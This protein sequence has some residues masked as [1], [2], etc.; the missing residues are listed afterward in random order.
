MSNLC[1]VYCRVSTN[2]QD[3]AMQVKMGTTLAQKLGFKEEE[4]TLI[5]DHG[6][7][8]LKVSAHERA[9]LVELRKLVESNRVNTL[10]VYDRDRIARNTIEY[11]SF[12]DVLAKHRVNMVFSNPLAE[13]FD[14]KLSRE[15]QLALDAENEG[16]KIVARTV[17]ASKYYPQSLFGYNKL[18]TKGTTRYEIN[19]EDIKVVKNIFSEFS[20]I[21]TAEQFH[22][23]NKRYK[24]DSIDVIKIVVNPYYSGHLLHDDYNE[25]LTHIKPVTSVD[26]VRDN[27]E[28]LTTWG[29]LEKNISTKHKYFITNTNLN[30][31]CSICSQ[32][33]SLELRGNQ[34]TLKCNNHPKIKIE[35]SRLEEILENHLVYS[36]NK[37]DTSALK[38]GLDEKLLGLHQSLRDEVHQLQANHDSLEQQFKYVKMNEHKVKS[39]LKIIDDSESQLEQ[40]RQTINTLNALKLNIQELHDIIL[41]RCYEY[42]NTDLVLLINTFIDQVNLLRDHVQIF[43]RFSKYMKGAS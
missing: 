23:M 31:Y 26:T 39:L 38:A 17:Q 2:N 13:A 32:P 6:V 30:L 20:T 14:N 22:S 34:K 25:P 33:I 19:E 12:L 21:S 43:T 27:I 37:L 3:T 24:N 9:G 42:L 40:V 15:A 36:L 10:I 16:K 41:N 28:K 5:Q 35:I 4:I 7:S 11:L 18:G 29:V 8:S 1:I